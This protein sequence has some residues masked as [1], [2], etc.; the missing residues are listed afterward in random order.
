MRPRDKEEVEERSSFQTTSSRKGIHEK[1]LCPDKSGNVKKT[2]VTRYH[3]AIP[4]ILLFVIF[5][6]VNVNSTMP[7]SCS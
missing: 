3:D 7:M 1:M 2:K 5:P 6:S 4:A